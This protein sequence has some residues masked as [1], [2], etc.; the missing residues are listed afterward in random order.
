MDGINFASSHADGGPNIEIGGTGELLGY[1]LGF[2]V[3]VVFLRDVD[4]VRTGKIYSVT[5]LFAY[6][7][8]VHIVAVAAA[9]AAC[10]AASDTVIGIII[11]VIV[12][13]VWVARVVPDVVKGDE[14][15]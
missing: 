12:A 14:L 1:P 11:V 9:L 3:I 4:A 10:A 2:A 13:V 5:C 6:I 7:L 8:P 15:H